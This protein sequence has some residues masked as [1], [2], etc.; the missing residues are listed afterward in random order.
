MSAALPNPTRPICN[1][2]AGQIDSDGDASSEAGHDWL[3]DSEPLIELSSECA[4]FAY[5]F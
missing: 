3:D 4:E 1:A 5:P 2:A